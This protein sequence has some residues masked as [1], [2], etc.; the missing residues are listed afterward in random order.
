[1]SLSGNCFIYPAV[2]I[3]GG[4]QRKKGVSLFFL[5]LFSNVG[6]GYWFR[7][8]VSDIDFGYWFRILVSDIVP[9][10]QKPC[11]DSLCLPSDLFSDDNFEILI[12]KNYYFVQK[13]RQNLK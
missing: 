6:F 5:I 2:E 12:W 10:R 1:M 3:Y 13:G 8:L 7:I 4:S 11:F 9:G